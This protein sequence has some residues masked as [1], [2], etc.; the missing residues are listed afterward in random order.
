MTAKCVILADN[1]FKRGLRGFSVLASWNGAAR[2]FVPASAADSN[3]DPTI[4]PVWH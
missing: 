3:V 4:G 1:V 2:S